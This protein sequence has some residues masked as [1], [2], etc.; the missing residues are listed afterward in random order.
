MDYAIVFSSM[1]GNTELIARS[2][3]R[4]LGEQGC[5]YCGG[6]QDAPNLSGFEG[7]VFAG[8]WADKGA[9]APEMRT[10]MAA[11]GHAHVF[12]FGT[13]GFGQSDEYYN[14]VLTR[15]REALPATCELVG[16]FMCQGKMPPAV[17]ERYEGMLAAAQPG[18]PEAQRAQLFLDNFDQALAH[19][20]ADDLH[21]LDDALHEAGLA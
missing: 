13:C 19:P 2:I 1:T 10:W 18:S 9:A 7:V 12:V 5:V 15:M 16:S 3:R 11:L 4:M 6:P 21:A 17:R 14:Q 20:N 8:S